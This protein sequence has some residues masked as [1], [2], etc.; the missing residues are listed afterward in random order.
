MALAR[1]LVEV[2]P[3]GEAGDDVLL[4]LDEPT[5]HLD[6]DAIAWLEERLAAHRGGLVLVTHDRH[7]LD[8]VTTRILEL[9]R[10]HGYVHEGGYAAY[11]EA[12]AERE[13]QAD[14]PGAVR[15]NLARSELA[16]LRRGAPARTTQAEGAHRGGD[17]DRRGP[18]RGGGTRG[19][20]RPRL[21]RPA[22]RRQRR[23]SDTASATATATAGGC[24]AASTCRSIPASDSGSSGR[25]APA[26]RRCST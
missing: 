8:R 20:A 3:P 18:S 21:R 14:A 1:A 24:S 7:V 13:A 4:I 19:R 17:R 9:D 25:T 22:A 11:L 23:R 15:R 16:W 2:G 10:G 26:S 12:R 5:N 6:I